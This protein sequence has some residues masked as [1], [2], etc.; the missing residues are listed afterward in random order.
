MGRLSYRRRQQLPASVF[1]IPERRAYPLDT[2]RR[3]RNALARVARFGSQREQ[4]RVRAAVRRMWPSVHVTVPNPS[5]RPMLGNP[6]YDLRRAERLDRIYREARARGLPPREAERY[7][8]RAARRGTN[9]YGYYSTSDTYLERR[10][11]DRGEWIDLVVPLVALWLLVRS[12]VV[13]VGG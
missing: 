7:A 12:R 3:A 1:A 10:N 5:L 9:R 11:P 4:Q 13:R 2:L 6:R 8:L